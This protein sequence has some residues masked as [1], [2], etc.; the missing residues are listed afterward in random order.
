MGL[1]WLLVIHPSVSTGLSFLS[2]EN[3]QVSFL[4]CIEH[5][6][7][8]CVVAD[9]ALEDSACLVDW[10]YVSAVTEAIILNHQL[11]PSMSSV[12]CA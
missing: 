6:S 12:V 9:S 8:I 5:H 2:Q 4:T 7:L 10:V 11:F 1:K 3:L